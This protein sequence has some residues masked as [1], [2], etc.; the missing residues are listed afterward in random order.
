MILEERDYRLAF[1]A[2]AAFLKAYET[3]GLPVQRKHLGEPVGFFTTD[4]GELNRVV[5]MWRYSDHAERSAR[6]AAMLADPDW[7]AY[8]EAIKGLID[9]QTIRI[10]TPAP[11][12]PLR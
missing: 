5:S 2:T 1:G 3:L 8:L 11:F 12:S 7:P 10:L 9:V 6:R 4:V